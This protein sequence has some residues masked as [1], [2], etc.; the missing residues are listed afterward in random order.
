MIVTTRAD[1]TFRMKTSLRASAVL[2]LAPLVA[3]AWMTPAE[4]VHPIPQKAVQAAPKTPP[5]EDLERAIFES[6]NR[7]RAARNLPPVRPSPALTALARKQS[8]DMA[9]RGILVHHSSAGKSYMGR[10]TDAGILFAAN[11]ENVAR[12]NSSD[13]KRIHEALMGSGGH[14]ENIL[15]PDFDELGVG[16]VKGQ[17][18][19]CYVSQDFIKGVVVRDEAGARAVIL[20]A[21]DKARKSRGLAP[22]LPVNDVHMTAQAFAVARSEGRPLPE[23]PAAYGETQVFFYMGPDLDRLAAAMDE[24]P[25]ERYRM[26]GVGVLFAQSPEHPGGAYYVCTFLLIGDPALQW[27]DEERVGEVLKAMN[28]VRANRNRKPLELDAGLSRTAAD[29]GSRYKKGESKLALPKSK[30]VAVLY[31]TQKLGRLAPDLRSHVSNKV[32]RKVGISV[33]PAEAGTGLKVNFLVVIILDE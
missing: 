23:V 24:N 18:G 9:G 26:T 21:M 16:I 22:L 32:H 5:L 33:L 31:E 2:V 13:P 29:L 15:H 20:A 19:N 1:P 6:V 12:S 10:L 3:G 17:D 8:E 11:G 28:E 30:S 4:R 14:R 7:E 27:S 25:L